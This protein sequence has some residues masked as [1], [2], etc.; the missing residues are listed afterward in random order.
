MSE[1][2]QTIPIAKPWMG[3]AEAEAARR[4][5]MSAWVTQSPEV[6]TFETEFADYLGSNLKTLSTTIG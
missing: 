5:I 1:K 3:E 6:A 4:P 2:I